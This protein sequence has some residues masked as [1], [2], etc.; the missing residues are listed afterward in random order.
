MYLLSIL[1][2]LLFFQFTPQ[3]RALIDP[4]PVTGCVV[5]L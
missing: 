1:Y 2:G 3:Q 5:C 4:P